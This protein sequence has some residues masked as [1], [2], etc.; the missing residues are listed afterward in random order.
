[1]LKNFILHLFIVFGLALPVKAADIMVL[2]DSLSAG[3]GLTPGEGWVE[4]MEQRLEGSGL[5]LLNAS[6]SGE[7]TAG[8]LAR[9]PDLLELH[10]PKWVLLELG[11]N[12]GLRGTPLNIIQTNL[13]ALANKITE[14]GAKLIVIGIQLPPNYGPRYTRAF[15]NLFP[16]L[17]DAFD[18][19]LVPF[20]L[21]GVATDWDLMQ[22]DGLHPKAVAQPII[23]KTVMSV[24]GPE[25]GVQ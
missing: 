12:D 21:E 17:A 16:Q 10:E 23:L 11:A 5:T 15:F 1:M 14:S 3:Y 22:S 8:G 2:G 25:I 4:L 18:A 24:V 19:P 9:L 20:L 13:E 6:V 7:T